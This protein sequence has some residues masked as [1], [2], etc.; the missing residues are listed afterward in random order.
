MHDFVAKVREIRG[1]VIRIRAFYLLLD[2]LSLFL[3]FSLLT[4]LFGLPL[5]YAIAPAFFFT[6]W[7]LRKK[8]DVLE[9]LAGRYDYFRERLRAAYD[10]RDED[11]LVMRHLSAEVSARL[12]EVRYSSFLSH[13]KALIRI[14]IPVVLS[15]A[16]VSMAFADIEPLDISLPMLQPR[17][18]RDASPGG[19]VET[20]LQELGKGGEE[21]IFGSPSIA[22]IEGKEAELELYPSGGEVRVRQ[23]KEERKFAE[24]QESVPEL[25]PSEAFAENIPEKYEEV[26]REYF[27]KLAAG[28]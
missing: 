10:N 27:E 8:L 19:A 13:R 28:G 4:M 25:E 18:T 22:K 1:A 26:I 2:G 24:A 17:E 15:F 14:L 3:F 21:D 16:I 9:E 5:L 6:A 23:M 12:S 11:N 7:M 20:G